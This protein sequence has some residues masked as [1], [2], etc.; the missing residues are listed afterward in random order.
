[1]QDY[2]VLHSIDI[3]CVIPVMVFVVTAHLATKH[4]S[5][6]LWLWLTMMWTMSKTPR[7]QTTGEIGIQASID[8][9]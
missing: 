8:F 6:D 1:M 4:S 2:F 7:E 5:S 3:N 9:N